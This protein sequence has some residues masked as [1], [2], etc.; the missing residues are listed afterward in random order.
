M[1]EYLRGEVHY[2][3]YK[4]EDELRTIYVDFAFTDTVKKNQ[5]SDNTVI[6]CMSGYPNEDRDQILRN[7]EYMETYSGGKK[8]ESILRIRELFYLYEADVLIV[9]KLMSTL[10]LFNCWEL[11]RVLQVC[12]NWT[13]S[14][15]GYS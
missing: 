2:F 1:C 3:R 9:D 7:L 15:Q 4:L 12:R 8:D 14:S 10:N 5:V 6:G 13:I 11:L